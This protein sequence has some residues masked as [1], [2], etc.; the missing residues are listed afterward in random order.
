MDRIPRSVNTSRTGRRWPS[1]EASES[2]PP[3]WSVSRNRGAGVPTAR[4][5]AISVSRAEVSS[6]R[7][8]NARAGSS[9]TTAAPANAAATVGLP[10]SAATQSA[11]AAR[12][13]FRA[14]VLG[15]AGAE[16]S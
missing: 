5:S 15:P 13:R 3:D 2:S 6:R 10:S 4:P 7:H 9:D 14:T 12:T 11:I 1:R 8:A 16:W